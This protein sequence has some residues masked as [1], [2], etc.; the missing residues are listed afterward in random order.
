M[1]I[2]IPMKLMTLSSMTKSLKSLKKVTQM[3]QF[4]EKIEAGIRDHSLAEVS[5]NMSILKIMICSMSSFEIAKIS[6]QLFSRH[7]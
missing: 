7:Q 2:L 3:L 5:K 6:K 4:Q 1:L